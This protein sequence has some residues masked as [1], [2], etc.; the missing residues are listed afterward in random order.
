MYHA[1]GASLRPAAVESINLLNYSC[2]TAC[3]KAGLFDP[4]QRR[5]AGR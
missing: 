5:F 2:Y 1:T 4:L 3:E